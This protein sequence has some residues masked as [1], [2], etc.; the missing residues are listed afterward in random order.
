VSNGIA[1][2]REA[3]AFKLRRRASAQRGG[4]GR[5]RDINV[6]TGLRLGRRGK[7]RVGSGDD[8]EQDRSAAAG[9][10]QSPDC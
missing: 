3:D 9:R 7:D 8:S 10:R 1:I 5:D 6:V 2:E 4:H